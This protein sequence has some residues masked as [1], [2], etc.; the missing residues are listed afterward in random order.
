MAMH[1]KELTALPGPSGS[2]DAVRAYILDQALKLTGEA[3]VDRLG[4]VIAIKRGTAAN[5]ATVMACAHMD[6]VAFLITRVEDSGLLR[7]EATGS[8]DSRILPSQRVLIRGSLRGVIGSMPVHLLKPEDI[9]KPPKIDEMYIDIGAA[10]RNGALK[11]AKPGDWAV[12]DSPYVEFGERL[13]KA[14]ALDDRAGCSLLL[15]AL[16]GRYPATLVAVFSAMEEI[17][18]LGAMAAAYAVRPD[19]ACVLEGTTCADMHG[20]P[21]HLRVTVI[22]RGPA[23]TVMDHSAISDEKLREYLIAAAMRENIPWQHRAG[24]F[25]GTDAGHIQPAH[26]GV[27]VVNINVPCRYIHSPVSVMSLDD[28]GNAL[29]LL[30][31]FL[32]GIQEHI[33]EGGKK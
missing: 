5:P 4:S 8:V 28:Y 3:R 23:I 2:E 12:F 22:G 11:L 33:E 32:G 29:K 10:D 9:K 27:P 15:E 1:I 19:A 6:E 31:V 25:G 30:K 24:S 26:A 21:D 17:G 13:V 14:K 7:F 18:S 16:E 20:V